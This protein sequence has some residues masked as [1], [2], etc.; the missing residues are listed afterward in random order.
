KLSLAI[1]LALVGGNAFALGLGTI[2][3]RSKLNQPLEAVI[4]VIADS[5]AEATGLEVSLASAE[6]FQRVGLDR[7]RV[8]VPL[9]FS[10]AT[11]RGQT[12][13]KVSTKDI[14]REPLVDFL[15]VANWPKGKLLREYTVLLDPPVTAPAAGA[16]A[17][18]PAHEAPRAKPQ[19][20]PPEHEHAAPKPA[21]AKPAAARPAPAPR[22]AGSGEYGPV[23]A[24]ETLS[25][26]A[27][28]T[29]PDDKTN[30]DA[31]MLA[32]L[33]ANPNAFYRDNINALKRGAIL[34]IPNADEIKAGGN[35][36]AVAAAVR[37]QNQAWASNAPVAKP[38][39]VAKTGAPKSEA[40]SPAAHKET[41]SAGSS[42]LALVPPGAGKGKQNS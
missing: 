22:A 19:P 34:R 5:P 24:G 42:H 21:Q 4:P 7:S 23:A 36:A 30:L 28:A 35:A 38:T 6:D 18:S 14:V 27:G 13:I 37:D 39:L 25:E 15:I 12:V 3:V 10:V 26:I 32:L 20:L 8:D 16:A 41:V 33:K 11:E 29:R 1:A 31:M 9:E 17:L 2:Q 40:A